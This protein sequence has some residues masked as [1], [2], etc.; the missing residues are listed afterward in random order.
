VD[1][2]LSPTVAEGLQQNGHDVVHVRDYG[3]QAADDERIF[4]RCAAALFLVCRSGRGPPEIAGYGASHRCS[5]RLR[6][7]F[8][9][10]SPE[11]GDEH[12][13]RNPKLLPR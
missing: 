12:T 1:N 13:T 4:A 10:Q 8:R 6:G 11:D 3:L 2:A 5:R 7:A 9:S